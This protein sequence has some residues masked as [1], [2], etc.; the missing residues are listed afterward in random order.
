MCMNKNYKV[1]AVLAAYAVV[2]VHVLCQPVKYCH[3]WCVNLASIHPFIHLIDFRKNSFQKNQY[4]HFS[5]LL[6]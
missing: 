6:L 5:S 4:L 1:N 2:L 3:S